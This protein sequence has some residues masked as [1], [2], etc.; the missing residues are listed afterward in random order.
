MI[1]IHTHVLQG[2]DHGANNLNDSLSMLE[3][4][5]STGVDKVYCTSHYYS[6]AESEDSF[7]SRYNQ[8]FDIL[9]SAYKGKI[10]LLK[11]AEVHISPFFGIGEVQ[12]V[13]LENT[14]FMLIELPFWQEFP[15]WTYDVIEKLVGLGITPIIAHVERYVGARKKRIIKRLSKMGALMHVDS[16]AVVSND[17]FVDWC[18]KKGFVKVVASDYHHDIPYVSIVDAISSIEKKHGK[19]IAQTICSAPDKLLGI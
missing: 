1:D 14:N 15:D 10:K 12:K 3:K 8:A 16:T 5:E 18:I 17:H 4:L 13:C 9:S 6:D 2:V 11:G 7:L 19:E